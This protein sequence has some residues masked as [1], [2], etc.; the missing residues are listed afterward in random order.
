MTAQNTSLSAEIENP[1]IKRQ[2]WGPW[3]TL[4]LGLVVGIVYLIT[5]VFVVVIFAIAK[6]ISDSTLSPL[7]LVETLISDGLLISL[8]TFAS[9]IVCVGLI[10]VIIKIRGRATIA[11]YLGL[12]RITKKTILILLAIT[13]GIIVLS[14]ILTLILGKPL[15]P[16]FMVNAYNTSIWPAL[17][18]IAV[19]IFAPLFEEVFFRGFLFVGFRQSRI[20]VVGTI[21]LTALIWAL[22]HVQYGV[23]E[24]TTIFVLGIVLGIIRFKTDSLWSPLLMH[25]FM[26]LIAT[27]EVSL[28]VNA[29][30]G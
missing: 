11:K 30:V 26:N 24:I 17:F 28:N 21:G 9:A 22:M 4:G 29:L 13:T 8:A 27:L 25:V 7:Q 10:L 19:V 5:Q 15:N 6:I 16:E 20:G 12:R 18:W 1:Q 14:D 3:S 2:L 23:Y